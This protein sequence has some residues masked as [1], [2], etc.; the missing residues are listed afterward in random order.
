MAYK[1]LELTPLYR[2]WPIV[3]LS[4]ACGLVLAILLSLIHSLDYSATTRVLITQ[5]LGSVDAYTASRSAERIVDDL[6]GVLYTSD[7]F[8]K[9]MNSGY[10]IDK[11]FFSTDEIKRREQW[12]KAVTASTSLSS[13][14]LA[15]RAYHPDPE[16]AKEIASAVA[17]IYVTQGWTYISGGDITVQVVDEPLN[18]R[19]PVRPNLPVN[20]ISGFFL[21]AIAGAAYVYIQAERRKGRHSLIH[22]GDE[23]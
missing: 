3:L 9:V 16:Q 22:S 19:Y 17:Y 21:G 5:E 23:S 12:E 14:M 13:G 10:K 15:I 8:N 18:S 6:S 20:G 7:F 1:Y 2:G 4:A 11:S